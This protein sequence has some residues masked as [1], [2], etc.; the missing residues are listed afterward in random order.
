MSFFTSFFNRT[1]IKPQKIEIGDTVCLGHYRQYGDIP[2]NVEWLVVNIEYGKALLISKYALITS[3]YCCLPLKSYR[4]LEWEG[5]LA[6]EKCREFFEV[7]FSQ[8]EQSVICEKKIEMNGFGKDCFDRV[9]LLS[10]EEV[11]LYF[12]EAEERKCQPTSKAKADGAQMG[13]TDDTQDYTSWWLLPECENGGISKLYGS[14]EEYKGTIYPKAVFQ[15]GEIQY[16]SR[17]IY[18]QNFC[19]RPS[20]LVEIEKLH[21]Q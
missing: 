7:C 20:I 17:N 18:H 16:H 9:F 6:R 2:T 13:W 4:Q 11:K 19:I 10:E 5:S 8:S 14:D 1:S 15:M 3:G 21:A 12:A